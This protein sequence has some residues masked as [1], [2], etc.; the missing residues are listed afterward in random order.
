[1]LRYSQPLTKGAKALT[2]KD[3][4]K[5]VKKDEQDLEERTEEE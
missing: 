3:L 1:M 2:D 5:E 4:D